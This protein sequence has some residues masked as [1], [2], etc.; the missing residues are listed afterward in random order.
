[1]SNLKPESK[2]TLGYS[3]A[4]YSTRDQWELYGYNAST[5]NKETAKRLYKHA[6][7]HFEEC[8]YLCYTSI[9]ERTKR[10]ERLNINQEMDK[11][12]S[13][14]VQVMKRLL[15]IKIQEI[16]TPYLTVEPVLKDKRVIVGSLGL[17][18]LDFNGKPEQVKYLSSTAI[19]LYWYH[20]DYVNISIEGLTS[21]YNWLENGGLS[22]LNQSKG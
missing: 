6:L 5:H 16:I 3:I 8:R 10:L 21:L 15:I 12:H 19:G 22:P 1:M 9:E 18:H 20:C 11:L 7:V 17:T 13:V 14:T 4:V 2:A